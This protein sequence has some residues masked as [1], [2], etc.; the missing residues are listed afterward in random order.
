MVIEHE[1]VILTFESIA[2]F[3]ALVC[4]HLPYGEG[5]FVSYALVFISINRQSSLTVERM[6]D[7]TRLS[8][9]HL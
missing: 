8:S 2:V 4:P 3:V 9:R 7:L 6:T 1:Y 5:C